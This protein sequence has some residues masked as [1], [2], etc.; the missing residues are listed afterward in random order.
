MKL[1]LDGVIREWAPKNSTVSDEVESV[2]QH[3]I[4]YLSSDVEHLPMNGHILITTHTAIVQSFRNNP[5][6]FK[7]VLL[8]VDEAHHVLYSENDALEEGEE[9]E[10]IKNRFGAI[11]KQSIL[12]PELNI[13]FHFATATYC[14]GD[15]LNIVPE[16]YYDKFT[17]YSMPMSRYLEEEFKYLKGFQYSFN[18]YKNSP[19]ESLMVELRVFK[20]FIG[21]IANGDPSHKNVKVEEYIGA[22]AQSKSPNWKENANGTISA[23]S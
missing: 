21:Y 6:L 19:L 20:K 22:S 16:Q 1:S 9:R 11:L 23:I 4:G 12:N 10:L 15:H 7:N 5:E 2:I 18:L 3:V 14:R 8:I 13:R 17:T